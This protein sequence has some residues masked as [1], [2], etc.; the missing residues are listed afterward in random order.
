MRLLR[1]NAATRMPLW[2]IFLAPNLLQDF[3]M[4][5]WILILALAG[6]LSACDRA[7]PQRASGSNEGS[8]LQSAAGGSAN[9]GK[10]ARSATS[11]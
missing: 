5:L 1:I 3:A 2:L 10:A 8:A 11:R 9:E 6:V 4:R 7:A